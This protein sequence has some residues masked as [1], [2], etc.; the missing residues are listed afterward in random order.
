VSRGSEN[1]LKIR[2]T[3]LRAKVERLETERENVEK[4]QRGRAQELRRR[5][6]IIDDLR[7]QLA[8][9]RAEIKECE[10]SPRTSRPETG[11]PDQEVRGE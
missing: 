11:C 9:I 2:N 7:D 1:A 5:Q 3:E 10:V 4:W 8:A 6:F